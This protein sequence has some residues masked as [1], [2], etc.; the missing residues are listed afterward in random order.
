MI[1]HTKQ[2]KGSVQLVR[3]KVIGYLKLFS[4]KENVEQNNKQ[5]QD[6]I[7]LKKIVILP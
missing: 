3:F 2:M 1:P 4:S 6:N 7:L 5:V